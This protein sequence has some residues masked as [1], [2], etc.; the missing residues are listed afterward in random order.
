M[1]TYKE[2]KGDVVERVASD[3]TNPG[4]GDIWY[5][6]TT[7]TLKG[8][9]NIGGSFSSGGNLNTTRR[10]L[11]GAGT[12]TAGLAFGGVTRSD[13]FV[14]TY[15]S[16]NEEYDGTSWTEVNDLSTAI[17]RQG[18]AGSQTSALSFGGY[19]S[20]LP[21][22]N[23]GTEEYNGTNWTSGGSM[24]TGRYALAGTG[25]QTAAVGTTGVKVNPSPPPNYHAINNN[26]EYDG[27]TWTS[28][29]VYPASIN[30]LRAAGTQTA[31][32]MSGGYNPALPMYT[33][34]SNEYDGSSWTSGGSLNTAKSA[35]AMSGIQTAATYIGGYGGPS[36]PAAVA[37]DK[38]EIYDGTSWTVQSATL[39][40]ARNELGSS[41]QGTTSSTMVF[42]GGPPAN[43]LS[44]TEEF[45]EPTL[46]TQTLTTS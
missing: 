23:S 38:I 27:S 25:T 35:G 41:E 34:V 45:T 28:A 24:G 44:V 29:T 9:Q 17:S 14:T 1:T 30:E 42:G 8:Y 40:T 12:L 10:S 16:A 21:G 31:A 18:S 20:P 7:G 4:E 5:N 32:I 37:Q 19:N 6:T 26:E 13:T 46:Q 11:G 15:Y 33:T 2:I 36:V 39:A 43:G 3:P 22:V